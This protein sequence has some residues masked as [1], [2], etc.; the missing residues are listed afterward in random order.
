MKARLKVKDVPTLA[1]SL[2][3]F[4]MYVGGGEE[5]QWLL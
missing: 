4:G 3:A 5:R 1:V 2:V